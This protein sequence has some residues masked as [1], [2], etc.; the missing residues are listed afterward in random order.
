MQN[1]IQKSFILKNSLAAVSATIFNDGLI[2]SDGIE[3]YLYRFDEEGRHSCVIQ[4]ARPYRRIRISGECITALGSDCSE[5]KIY[6][7]DRNFQ[8]YDYVR[9][10]ISGCGCGCTCNCEDF[11]ELT[12]ASLTKI[13]SEIFIIGVFRNGAYLFDNSGKRLTKLCATSQSEILTDFISLGNDVFA[14]S[15]ID[16]NTRTITIRDNGHESSAILDRMYTL[17]MLFEHN[18]EIYGLFGKNYI[19]NRIIKIYSNGL[20][21]LPNNTGLCCE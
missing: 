15:T 20:L 5:P 14:M 12:D 17:R 4:T 11:G 3:C 16:V 18:G 21:L 2:A 13:G 10:D 1:N 19:Y 9:L 7:I 8:E 6:L